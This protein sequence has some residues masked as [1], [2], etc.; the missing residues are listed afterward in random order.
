MRVIAIL[1]STLFAVAAVNAAVIDQPVRR[2]SHLSPASRHEAEPLLGRGHQ[3]RA[4]EAEP[5][6]AFWRREAEPYQKTW[7]REAEPGVRNAY[8][9]REPEPALA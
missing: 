5:G 3:E 2:D 1:L 8:W 9:R 4:A 7:K 6:Q